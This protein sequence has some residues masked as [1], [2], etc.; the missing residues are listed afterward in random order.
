VLIGGLFL[1]EFN[2][3]GRITPKKG[4]LFVDNS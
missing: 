3:S 1:V 4:T 2:D